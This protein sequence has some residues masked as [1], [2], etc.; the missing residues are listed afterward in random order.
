M[1]GPVLGATSGSSAG[2]SADDFV[3]TQNTYSWADNGW[4]Y[5]GAGTSGLAVIGTTESDSGATA[6]DAG[7]SASAVSGGDSVGIVAISQ[8]NGYAYD[9]DPNGVTDAGAIS[10]ATGDVVATGGNAWST[11]YP[12][13]YAAAGGSAFGFP[14]YAD[15]SAFADAYI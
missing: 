13:S 6:S 3:A 15:S 11:T 12:E 8:S 2:A 5:A 1:A 9:D 4:E 14:G 7:M 10:S